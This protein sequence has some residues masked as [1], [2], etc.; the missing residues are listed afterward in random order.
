MMSEYGQV[1]LKGRTKQG[2]QTNLEL[3]DESDTDWL[4]K[5]EMAR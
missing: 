3:K 5:C 2:I 1:Y 4:P